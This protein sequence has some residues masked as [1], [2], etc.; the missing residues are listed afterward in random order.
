M[1]QGQLFSAWAGC[2][3]EIKY[4]D[5]CPL[6][7]GWKAFLYNVQGYTYEI[8]LKVIAKLPP[9]LPEDGQ[10]CSY[11]PLDVSLR[12]PMSPQKSRGRFQH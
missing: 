8:D 6:K 12:H 5:F 9:F 4:F 11:G 7:L 3:F 2:N 1:G 10:N